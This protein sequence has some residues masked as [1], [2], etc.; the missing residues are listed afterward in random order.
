MDL[1]R[2]TPTLAVTP[3][4]APADLR[5]LA[6]SGYTTVI[7]NRPDGEQLGQPDHDTMAAAAQA[8][9]LD[10]VFQPVVSGQIQPAQVQAFADALAKAPGPV[11][12]YCRTGTR[13]ATLWALSQAATQPWDT[14][15]A[16]TA[17]QGFDLS[18]L[19]RPRP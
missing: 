8:A 6:A 13:C 10:F 11:L 9:G 18:R 4:I 15:M 7:C 5:T 12:A 14:L 16:T 1:K 17:A 19:P 3:Q 2:L